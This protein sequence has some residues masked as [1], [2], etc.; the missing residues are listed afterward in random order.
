MKSKQTLRNSSSCS[1]QFRPSNTSKGIE[2]GLE[3]VGQSSVNKTIN[4]E[5]TKCGGG[6]VNIQKIKD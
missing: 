4:V 6:Q 1:S 3:N 5:G 2:F